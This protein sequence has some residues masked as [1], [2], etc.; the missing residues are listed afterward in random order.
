MT[1]LKFNTVCKL[2]RFIYGMLHFLLFFGP[3]LSKQNSLKNLFS[4]ADNTHYFILLWLSVI[5][6]SNFYSHPFV[7][8]YSYNACVKSYNKNLVW[9]ASGSRHTGAVPIATAYFTSKCFKPVIAE[10]EK[11]LHLKESFPIVLLFTSLAYASSIICIL[12]R[13]FLTNNRS[14]MEL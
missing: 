3:F 13:Y 5:A 14:F 4:C 11:I 12:I 10:L 8:S 7:G 6:H 2:I 9:I 1:Y